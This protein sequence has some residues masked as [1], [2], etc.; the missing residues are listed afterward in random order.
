MVSNDNGSDTFSWDF[1]YR[2]YEEF[3]HGYHD[4]MRFK[5]QNILLVSSPYD[6][7]TLEEDGRLSEQI[8]GEYK[9]LGLSFP[10]RVYSVPSG[11]IALEEIKK[12]NYD[13]VI[14]MSQI[15]DMDPNVFGRRAKGIRPEVPIVLLATDMATLLNYHVPGDRRVFDKVFLW[16]GDS[17]LFLAIIKYFEDLK[18]VVEDTEKASVRIILIIEDSARYYSSFLS[19]IY[20]EV[21][22]QTQEVATKGLNEHDKMLLRRARPKI[23]LAETYEEAKWI[24][25]KYSKYM[26]GLITDISFPMGGG[27]VKDAGFIFLKELDDSL[28]VLL[29]SSE[30]ANSKRAEELGFTFLDKNS[31]NLL[32]G[33]SDFFNYELGFGDFIF[34]TRDGREIA[35]ASDVREFVGLINNVPSESIRFHEKRY[36]FSRWLFARC[37][38]KLGNK[39]KNKRFSDFRSVNKVREYLINVISKNRRKKQLGVITDFTQQNFE[40]EKSFTRYGSGSLGGKGRGIGFLSAML[41]M[42]RIN[43]SHPDFNITIPDT[44]VITT[45]EFDNFIKDNALHFLIDDDI[46]DEEV[47]GKFVSGK[48]REE[49]VNSLNRYLEHVDVPLAVRS[50]SLLED[51]LHQPFAGIYSTYLLPNNHNSF[52]KRMV[53]LETSIKLVFASAYFRSAKNYIKSTYQKVEEEKMAVVIQKLVGERFGHRFYPHF[54][55]VAVSKNYYPLHPL[56]RDEGICSLAVG[57]GKM[58]VDGGKVLNF[59]PEKPKLLPGFSTVNEILQNS[60]KDFYCLNLDNKDFDLE[61]GEEVTLDVQNISEALKDGVLDMISSIYVPSDDIIRDGP[62]HKGNLLITFAGILKYDQYPLPDIIKKIVDIGVKGLGGPVELEFAVAKDKE[63]K[64]EFNI[65]QIR[66]IISTREYK[67]VEIDLEQDTE[68]LFLLSNKAFGNGLFDD[69]RDIVVISP[70]AMDRRATVEIAH[71]VDK[72]NRELASSKYLLIGPGR[73]GT[74]DRWLGIPVKWDNICNVGVIVET[75]MPDISVNPS[76]GSHFFHNLTALGIPYLTISE[77][78]DEDMID[79]DWLNEIDPVW[80]GDYVRQ[81]RLDAPLTVKVDGKAGKGLV[82]RI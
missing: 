47:M 2:D 42:S 36:E 28:P 66:P 5:I 32:R 24:Y 73:W 39:I 51:S 4:L 14:T 56:K 76:Q 18:N 25:G 15:F 71:E 62:H 57:L 12:T 35:R 26:L 68:G 60:Q 20:K 38:F 11:K 43:K 27:E 17:A 54:S 31:E 45:S 52:H 40:F 3:F 6:A 81:I 59:S 69:I 19:I 48:L 1:S 37:E 9:E 79:W 65:L 8:F 72:V 50:S 64:L 22:R 21:M 74:S 49:L 70:D 77:K 61:S 41:R 10:P 30:K 44:L 34:R 46:E 58:V 29:H 78:P 23:L 16:S 13:L 80:Q 75:P 55:G 63:G 67:D 53:H 33:V 7:F 82:K